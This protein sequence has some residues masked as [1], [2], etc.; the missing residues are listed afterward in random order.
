MLT[1]FLAACLTAATAVADEGLLFHAPFDGSLDA[2]SLGGA[3]NPA[4]VTGA[5]QPTFAPGKFGQALLGGPE[6]ALVHYQT[7]GNVMP[8]SGTISLWV[9]PLNWTLDDGSFHVFFESGTGAGATGWLILYQFYQGGQLLLR[10]ADELQR[11]GM[12]SA[13]GLGWQ[14]GDWHHLAGTWS[15]EAERLYVDGELAA[16][17]PTPLVAQTL[18]ETFAL[19]DSG[20]HVPHAGAQTL[21]DDVRI[22]AHPLTP[23]RIRELAGH[24]SL[25][26]A[27]GPTEGAWQAEFRMSARE[28]VKRVRFEV[29]ADAGGAALRT[30]EAEMSEGVARAEF[31]VADLAPGEYR[32]TAQALDAQAAV[33]ADGTAQVKR[34]EQ[35][36]VVLANAQLR[37]VFDGGTGAVTAI[38]APALGFTARAATAPPALFSLDTVRFLEHARFYQPTDVKVLAAGESHLKSIVVER[39]AQGQRLTAEYAFAPEITATLVADLADEDSVAQ[40]RLRVAN[41]LPVKPSEALRV[42]RIAFPRLGGLRVGE[43][44]DDD[45]LATGYIHGET[46]A[47]PA[48]KLPAERTV[49]YPGT[50]CLPWQ[51]LYDPAGGLYLGPQTDGTC[52]L[53]ITAGA[54]DGAM[55]LGNRWWALLEPGEVWQSPVVELGVHAGA[56][57][58]GADRFRDWALQ[59]TPPRTPPAWLSECDGWLGLGSPVYQFRD[60][61]KV[62]EAAKYYGFSYLQLWSQMILGDQYYCYFYPNPDLGTEDELRQGIAQ[63]HAQGGQ[64]GFYSNVICFDGAIDR[65]PQLQ[66]K[67][68]QYGLKDLPMLPRF[69]DEAAKSVYVGPSGAYGRSA[70][71]YLDGYWAM[72]PCAPWWRDYLANW[73]RRWHEDYGADIWYLDSFPVHGYG[74]GPASYAL[75]LD[76]PQSLGGGQIGLLQRI[77]E[78]FDGPML[79]EGVACAAFMPYTNWC[80]GTQLS[81]GSGAW[82]R[83]E[84]LDYSF[85]DVYPVFAGSCNVWTGIGQIWPDLEKPRH[86]DAMN[87]VFLNGERFDTLGL[88]PLDTQSPFGEHVR[89]LVALRRKIRDIVYQGRFRDTLGLSGTPEGVSARLF[90]G[91]GLGAAVTIVD[92]RKE[93]A[94]W[95]LRVEGLAAAS[96]RLLLLDGSEEQLD[97]R[98]DGQALLLEISPPTEVCAIRFG[99]G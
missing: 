5:A 33:V 6:Q 75:H 99:E 57:H 51:D 89:K 43:K 39:T 23:E 81:F 36:R 42:P 93:R 74:L 58:W 25:T 86:E 53:E 24:G 20:W 19:G 21:I 8:P 83:P 2:Y 61:P 45:T 76:H 22:Y 34:L 88:Y 16:T 84:I 73:I 17:A 14:A 54:R 59:A 67:I 52:Q 32:V 49:Q 35:E 79:Y 85:S 48:A 31:P 4:Q 30:A 65:N 56:W 11:V 71:G 46:L 90:T 3:G 68:A 96:A 66:A 60:L 15:P 55:D 62:L 78:S 70:A 1:V 95:E 12:A 38:E 37:L 50:A 87:L 94:P 26:V 41:G 47:N 40:L 64:I 27:R 10:Y 29:L 44:A 72:D 98:H 18:G 13:Q 80:L 77:R 7:A 82:S 91:E 63:L 92:R 69:R 28:D 97:I 9:K